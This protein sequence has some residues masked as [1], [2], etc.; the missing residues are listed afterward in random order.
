MI[1]FPSGPAD[2]VSEKIFGEIPVVEYQAFLGL[3][4]SGDQNHL[5]C[6]AILALAADIAGD[7]TILTH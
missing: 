7:S 2:L 3:V 6:C 5:W 1:Q 4:G